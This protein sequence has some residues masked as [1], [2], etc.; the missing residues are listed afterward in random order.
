MTA[1]AYYVFKETNEPITIAE[2][3]DA[4]SR[5]RLKKPQNLSDVIGSCVRRGFLVDA[6][7]KDGAKA[8]VITG[9]GEEFVEESM[10]A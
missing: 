2:I 1:I 3:V 4:Y 6:D 5:A 10:N 9:K 7:R 8:W